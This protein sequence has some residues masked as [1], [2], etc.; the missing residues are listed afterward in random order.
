M[1]AVHQ[2]YQPVY[3]YIMYDNRCVIPTLWLISDSDSKSFF[4]YCQ[5]DNLEKSLY[6]AEEN[7]CCESI[8]QQAQQYQK[9]R[10][11]IF[12]SAKAD[13]DLEVHAGRCNCCGSICGPWQR[14]EIPLQGEV[15]AGFS[16]PVT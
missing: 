13:P 7:L 4:R 3:Y 12:I 15:V 1:H 9:K 2:P 6:Q 10:L 16:F 11:S 14:S 5:H 8:P